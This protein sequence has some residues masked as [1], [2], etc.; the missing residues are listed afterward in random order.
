MAENKNTVGLTIKI[1]ELESFI[2]DTLGS[3]KGTAWENVNIINKS[4]ASH[5]IVAS[6]FIKRAI[7][8]SKKTGVPLSEVFTKLEPYPDAI[9]T[10]SGKQIVSTVKGHPGSVTMH[11]TLSLTAGATPFPPHPDWRQ[12]KITGLKLLPHNVGGSSSAPN[13]A[14]IAAASSDTSPKGDAWLDE[15]F[16]GKKG[17]AKRKRS[18]FPSLDNISVGDWRYKE[19]PEAAKA[20]TVTQVFKDTAKISEYFP[21][22]KYSYFDYHER[23]YPSKS[24]IKNRGQAF[25]GFYNNNRVIPGTYHDLFQIRATKT[26]KLVG[27]VGVGDFSRIDNFYNGFDDTTNKRHHKG[28]ARAFYDKFDAARQHKLLYAT[29]PFADAG[30][31]VA[32]KVAGVGNSVFSALKALL[33]QSVP[34]NSALGVMSSLA[35]PA[36]GSVTSNSSST[37]RSGFLSGV[38]PLGSGGGIGGISGGGGGGSGPTPPSFLKGGLAGQAFEQFRH[39]AI[40]T[41]YTPILGAGAVIGSA[42]AGQQDYVSQPAFSLVGAGFNA[43]MRDDSRS[44]A[45]RSSGAYQHPQDK[46]KVLKAI[47][48]SF[49]DNPSEQNLP[50]LQKLSDRV[51]SAAQFTMG[52]E[53][54][55]AKF[56]GRTTTMAM[57]KDK[58]LKGA[59][60]EEV[61]SK[62][63][64]MM[65]GASETDTIKLQEIT[66]ASKYAMGP[67]LQQG[68][69]VPQVV[70]MNKYFIEEGLGA[71]Q[72]G[73]GFQKLA[74]GQPI[75]DRMAKTSI[76]RE[77]LEKAFDKYGYNRRAVNE[78]APLLG[79]RW[80]EQTLAKKN[81]ELLQRLTKRR[82]DI[83]AAMKGDV[84]GMAIEAINYGKNINYFQE[85][86][87]DTRKLADQ[88]TLPLL[89]S[90]AQMDSS[91]PLVNMVNKTEKSY[92]DPSKINQE[93]RARDLETNKPKGAASVIWNRTEEKLD[94]VANRYGVPVMKGI[95][96]GMNNE[97][98]ADSIQYSVLN[99][100][101]RATTNIVAAS[102]DLALR[103]EATPVTPETI[104]GINNLYSDTERAMSG[105]TMELDVLHKNDI[106]R[107]NWE[108][109]K[110]IGVATTE[111]GTLRRAGNSFINILGALGGKQLYEFLGAGN[112]KWADRPG[113][114]ENA[115]TGDTPFWGGKV[116]D[117]PNMPL[118]NMP[119]QGD[120][121]VSRKQIESGALTISPIINVYVDGVKQDSKQVNSTVNSEPTSPTQAPAGQSQ[122]TSK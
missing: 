16:F 87:Y 19:F 66:T 65:A 47:G 59:N 17:S 45:L 11:K 25:Q 56:A 18:A 38:S 122:G 108:G 61:F 96:G 50:M 68:F 24:D 102:R 21:K 23:I 100:D 44:W 5:E 97:S 120:I 35:K 48:S 26:G 95:I 32:S 15:V 106:Y 34:S 53:E 83:G 85:L 70:G 30:Q 84:K 54:D 99:K 9:H 91:Q 80:S 58:S 110:T 51:Q 111:A 112:T 64:D 92:N 104:R 20:A 28:D 31:F 40:W 13:V 67:M 14:Q 10:F 121:D 114:F 115:Y 43:K 55:I 7:S 41:A 94:K 71:S 8:S 27:S 98:I 118:G 57:G 37:S 82:A 81:P 88:Q 107:L 63:L 3:S 101:I 79:G 29:S 60:R 2:K 1:G 103:G 22:S 73:V 76:I 93:Q 42:L 12:Y 39:A 6:S 52:S 109:T 86:G 4:G 74:T 69:S 116:E 36:T 78:V 33:T 119:G 77:E 113:L 72:T 62:V 89:Y 117:F 90:F 105:D 46:L 49:G 75:V